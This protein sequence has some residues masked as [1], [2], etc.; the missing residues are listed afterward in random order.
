MNLLSDTKL[1]K[2]IPQ[3]IVDDSQV[4]KVSVD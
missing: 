1:P 4:V 3:Q 2:Y